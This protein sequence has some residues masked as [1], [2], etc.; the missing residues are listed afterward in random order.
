MA[1][2]SRYLRTENMWTHYPTVLIL[3]AT[4]DDL[5]EEYDLCAALVSFPETAS[6]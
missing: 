4:T 5:P 3:K 1:I 2:Y 6:L